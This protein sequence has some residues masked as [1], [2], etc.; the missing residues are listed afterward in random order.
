MARGDYEDRRA[1]RA[2]SATVG[3]VVILAVG[4]YG[5]ITLLPP[6]PAASV[7]VLDMPAATP[8]DALA[9]TPVLPIE[10][11]S[12][13]I[14]AGSSTLLGEAGI[15]EPVPMA[16]I[17][18]VITALV[19]LDEH[20]LDPGRNGD[21][22]TITAE[23]YASFLA[24][25]DAGS[26]AIPVVEGD[27]WTQRE[28]LTAVLLGS[29]NNHAELVAR[30]AYG[31]IDA[32][33]DAAAGWLQDNGLTDTTVVDPTG[34]DE[35][36]VGTAADLARLAQ[37]AGSTPFVNEVLP[38][39]EVTTSRGVVIVNEVMFRPDDGVRGLSRSVTNAAGICLLFALPIAS[40][41]T[42]TTVYGAFL[43]QPS[44]TQLELD[45]GAFVADAR[46][47][48][49]QVTLS[50]AGSTVVR[51]RS[52]WGQETT[53]VTRDA[54]Q[55]IGWTGAPPTG[56]VTTEEL[57]TVRKGTRVGTVSFAIDGEAQD[58]ALVT[59]SSLTDPGPGW[60]LLNPGPMAASFFS[61][62]FGPDGLLAD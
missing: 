54:L 9:G 55:S 10:G 59:T 51:F 5:P 44:Y 40:G 25:R 31:S 29:S 24:N 11:A 13:A 42:T 12:A 62:V 1:R 14:I 26:R 56:R 61:W 18:K 53:A 7:E 49:G 58:V 34:L 60:R 37:I 15:T 48:I 6:L 36:S 23:D 22:I 27:T 4:L 19:V 52:A 39:A 46:A 47:S 16:G 33:L 30:W 2:V 21:N 20:P 43:R 41:D 32:Y 8:D 38:M 17:A 3:A 28:A 35:R 57:R 45:V 50:E